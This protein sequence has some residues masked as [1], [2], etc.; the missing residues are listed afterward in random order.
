MKKDGKIVPKRVDYSDVRQSIRDMALI[1]KPTD[2]KSFVRN[3]VRKYN[4]QKG[5]EK[6][7]ESIV[8]ATLSKSTE[9]ESEGK[10]R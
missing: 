3:Y 8:N 6:E 1:Y 7:L 10:Q 5:F 9:V 2:V 4:I